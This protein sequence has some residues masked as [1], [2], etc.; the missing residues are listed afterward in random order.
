MSLQ[1][2]TNIAKECDVSSDGVFSYL[3][4]ITCWQLV[5]NEEYILYSILQ[6]N[7]AILDVYGVCGNM[8]AVQYAASEPFLGY[9]TSLSDSRTWEFRSKLAIALLNMVEALENTSYGTLYL[10][11]VQEPNFGIVSFNN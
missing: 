8:Y 5:T 11:D 1:V 10:C 2:A 6:G 7:S 3:E 4:T 9:L